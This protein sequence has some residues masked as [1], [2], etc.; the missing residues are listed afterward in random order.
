MAYNSSPMHFGATKGNRVEILHESLVEGKGTA[1]ST[2]EDSLAWAD[3]LAE[4]RAIE[5]LW[6]TAQRFANQWNPDT[7][8]DFLPRWERIYGIRHLLSDTLVERRAKVKAKI[9]MEGM[10][11]TFQVV[12]DL[13]RIVL[14]DVYVGL[15]H[16]SSTD[17]V[18]AVPGGV[19]VSGGVTLPSGSWYSTISYIAIETTQPSYMDNDTFYKKVGQIPQFLDDLLPAWVTYAW[20]KDG[21]G[22]PGFYLDQENN[23]DNQRFD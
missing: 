8:T 6:S 19:T 1:F 15:V 4:A 10:P 5:Y 11:P 14:G 12:N 21:V 18:G 17:A 9:E 22:G 3:S 2:D 7:M 23:L 20:F 16:T 13:L